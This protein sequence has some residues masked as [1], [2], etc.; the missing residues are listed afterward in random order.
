MSGETAQVMTP[1][2][3][4]GLVLVSMLSLIA[5]FALSAYAPE[6]RDESGGDSAR[7]VALG[8]RVRGPARPSGR[9]RHRQQ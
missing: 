9:R 3:A 5:Y 2:V 1:R 4:I 7:A 8:D 6:L